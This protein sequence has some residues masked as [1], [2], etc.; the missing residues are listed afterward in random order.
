MDS[1]IHPTPM[2]TKPRNIHLYSKANW[3]EMKETY[4]QL[5]TT[6]FSSTEMKRRTVNENWIKFKTTLEGLM[7]KFIPN[8]KVSRRYNL[9]WLTSSLKRQCRRKYKMFQKAKKN[10]DAQA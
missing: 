6:I 4:N 3:T 8:K 1:D 5:T 7:D 2:K 9:P 10:N